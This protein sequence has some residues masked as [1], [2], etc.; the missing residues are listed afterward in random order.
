MRAAIAGANR[1]VA[2]GRERVANPSMGNR[3]SASGDYP[4]VYF[5]EQ[6]YAGD[7]TNWWIPNASAL[8]G[9]LRAAG[10]RIRQRP[11]GEVVARRVSS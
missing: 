4:V 3:A 1:C 6:K 7:P 8:A 2:A 9:M 5:V 11:E 10:F